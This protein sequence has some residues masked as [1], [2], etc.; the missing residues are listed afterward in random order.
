MNTFRKWAWAYTALF[1]GVVALGYIP[2][3]TDKD[4]N[5]FGLFRIE[6]KD[7]ILHLG[8]AIWA[9]F[10]AWRSEWASRFYFRLFGSVYFLDGILGLLF[11]QAILDG[12]LFLFGV[13][14][15]DILGNLPGNIPHLII[16]GLAV[17]VGFMFRPKI[18]Q[19]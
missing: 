11:G 10:A 18:A 16:G 4:G 17:W 14:S 13:T 7:D 15:R 6:L 9:A 1:L 3:F 19:H 5:L 8:S 12:G 2:G